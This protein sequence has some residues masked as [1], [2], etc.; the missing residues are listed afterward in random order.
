MTFQF[1]SNTNTDAVSDKLVA[2]AYRMN[3]IPR[4]ALKCDVYGT[5]HVI[6]DQA[7]AMNIFNKVMGRKVTKTEAYA[8]LG[9]LQERLDDRN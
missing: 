1:N 4:K 9:V 8:A 5:V 3:K 7:H 2:F 6:V